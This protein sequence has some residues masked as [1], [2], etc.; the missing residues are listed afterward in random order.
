M[1]D[2]IYVNP[3]TDDNMLQN[4]LKKAGSTIIFESGTYTPTK[5]L[6]LTSNTHL[7]LSPAAVICRTGQFPIFQTCIS[8]STAGYRGQHDIL[9]EGGVIASSG[10]PLPGNMFNI[11]H[12][13][14]IRLN[15][16]TFLD[17]PSSHA[18][19]IN[20]SK[21]V[22]VD[23]CLFKGY[24]AAAASAYR[25]AVQID[26]ANYTALSYE[27]DKSAACY[28]LTHC[29]DISVQNCIFRESEK[30]PAPV[31]A[32][33]THTV[34]SNSKKH[35]NLQFCN[36]ICYGRGEYGGYGIAFCLEN[37]EHV[38]IMGNT[39][40]N[41]AR[42]CRILVPAKFYKANGSTTT[43]ENPA[44]GCE[45]VI[46]ADNTFEGAG[47]MKAGF[48]YINSSGGIYHKNII[49]SNNIFRRGTNKTVCYGVYAL[50]TEGLA[51]TANQFELCGGGTVIR[52][53]D[54]ASVIDGNNLIL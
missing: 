25:E 5:T 53:P 14:N 45:S 48:V 23:S 8:A 42:F 47:S 43:A 3:S 24:R 2:I 40:S 11:I 51:V 21:A 6:Q 1:S 19:E 35:R 29:E 13:S 12:A 18:I 16:I 46:L 34:T 28:D 52:N 26:F 32:I 39:C 33:G 17:I 30:N 27:K 10:C 41:Y 44:A 4:A 20:A 9:I 7:V 49:V 38:I 54:S 50:N 31:N 15:G 37:M 36:N 22:M